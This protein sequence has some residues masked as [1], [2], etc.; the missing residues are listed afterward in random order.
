MVSPLLSTKLYIP[1]LRP[2]SVPRPR[3]IEQLEGGLRRN[4]RLSLISAPPGF[5][6]TTLISEWV[7]GTD[8]AVGWLS[9]DEEDNDPAPFLSYLIAALQQVDASIG[10][11]IQPSLRS[12]Q[13]PPFEGLVTPLINDIVAVSK[14]FML[15][16][17]DY[18]LITSPPIH[19]IVAFLL[20][21]QPPQMHLVISTREDPPLPMARLRARDQMTEVRERDL[22][23]TGEEAA[24]FLRQT[25]GLTLSAEAVEALE[26]RTEGWIAGLQLAALAL[27]KEEDSAEGFIAA[28][29]GDDR[30]IMDYLIAEV[31]GRLP[32]RTRTFLR[33]TAILDRLSPSLCDAVT[34][35][36]DSRVILEQLETSN[37]FLIT[38]DN[39]REW[40]RY[41][42]LFAE[43]LRLTLGRERQARL[44]Q[45]AMQWYEAHRFT[46]QAIQHALAYGQASGD[47]DDAERL[48]GLAAARTIGRGAL[49]TVRGWLDALPDECIRSRPE[50][51]ISKGWLLSIDGEMAQAEEYASAAETALQGVEEQPDARRGELLLLRGFIALLG[52][53]DYTQATRLATDALELLPEDDAY[54]RV[55]ALW[56]MAEAQERTGP[57]T[58]AID[59]F[60]Q[61]QRVG[62]ALGD[63]AFTVTVDQALAAALNH[64]GQRREAVRVCEEA[65][66]RYTDDRGRVAPLAGLILSFLGTLYYEANQLDLARQY[67]DQGLEYAGQFGIAAYLVPA[68]GFRARMLYAVGEVDAAL[69]SL[70]LAQQA[71]GRTG[72]T[73]T[74]W[75]LAHEADL[76]LRQGD[77]S[78]ALYWAESAGLSPDDTPDYLQLDSHLAFA[79]LL[80]ARKRL[81]EARRWLARQESFIRERGLNRWLITVSILQSLV[82]ER[83]GEHKAACELLSRAVGIAAP[84]AYIRA[85]LD[86]DSQVLTLLPDIRQA[87][88]RF[89][90]ELLIHSYGQPP[91]RGRTPQPLVEPLSERE[92]EVL[93]LIAGGLSNAEIAARLFIAVGTV[94]RH[95]NNIYGKIN[96]TSRTQAI[97]KARELRLID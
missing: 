94:K 62:H 54:W 64:H 75:L 72:V 22:R 65:L 23:F 7:R 84:E 89:V 66:A 26:A 68:H 12:A 18:H 29:T 87:A 46:S 3:L 86:E 44:H 82:E 76:R 2:N 91:A 38:L 92:L 51:A 95:I 14:A 53:Q 83:S 1:S 58:H 43:M 15:V 97:V 4:R 69:K 47:L 45:R 6:K 11:T 10:Q 35:R 24:A 13:L 71:A 33:E 30:Y 74:S 28:F 61:A 19:Q 59:S 9:L 52:H 27:Q 93:D 16:L 67:L 81:D 36:E 8:R 25:M 63:Q 31:L 17:D 56:V 49:T 79:R 39:R 70:H 48:I 80:L 85:F 40:Y 90:D 73:S 88:P 57:V 34:G 20:E 32:E 50:L 55:I 78:F 77:L 5:G 60:R 42:R 96:V 41:H 21:H 37:L